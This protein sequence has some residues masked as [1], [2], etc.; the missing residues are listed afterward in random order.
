MAAIKSIPI[1]HLNQPDIRIWR[2]TNTGIFSVKSTYHLANEMENRK[3]LERSAPK[4]ESFQWKKIWKLPLPNATRNIFW[5]ACHNL[6]PTKDNLLKR[7]VV[8][9]LMC[10]I[11]ERE[12]EMVVHALWGC[13]VASDV[14]GGSSRVFQKSV[15]AVTNF[16][17]ASRTDLS[18][19]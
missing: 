15:Q 2:G 9:E 19:M 17:A 6:L 10:P 14:W 3:N 13:S 18:R 1:S 16:S 7:K 12:P 8:K 5:R 4:E 11:C